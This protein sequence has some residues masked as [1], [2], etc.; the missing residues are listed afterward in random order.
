MIALSASELLLVSDNDFGVEGTETK[1]W[2]V[3]LP[4]ALEL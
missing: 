2:R 4:M 3:V 1:F